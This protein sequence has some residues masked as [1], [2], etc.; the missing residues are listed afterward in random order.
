[1]SPG[2][3]PQLRFAF[4]SRGVPWHRQVSHQSTRDIVD[5]ELHR[6]AKDT[7]SR[8]FLEKSFLKTVKGAVEN[9][10]QM[11]GFHIKMFIYPRVDPIQTVWK[12]WGYQVCF[13]IGLTWT[14]VPWLGPPSS[15]GYYHFD[16]VIHCHPGACTQHLV[17]PRFVQFR[18]RVFVDMCH[19]MYVHIQILRV[20]SDTKPAQNAVSQ[21]EL[22]FSV[23]GATI[24]YTFF[25]NGKCPVSR[26]RFISLGKLPGL[27]PG[28][29]FT[30]HSVKWLCYKWAIMN[31]YI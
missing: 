14:Q 11:V 7:R 4:R 16:W 29:P 3:V 13:M 21:K 25:D 2:D 17:Y 18:R 9:D 8:N 31:I 30:T 15:G 20:C 24:I 26:E 23:A 27:L 19:F 6:G 12:E 5:N 1:M 28:R 10:L 22:S